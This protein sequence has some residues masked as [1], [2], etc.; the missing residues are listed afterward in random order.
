MSASRSACLKAFRIYPPWLFDATFPCPSRRNMRA[1]GILPGAPPT[2][3]AA[4]T[5]RKTKNG[6][7]VW[8]SSLKFS[9]QSKYN[10][11]KTA[12]S[13]SFCCPFHRR[14]AKREPVM[15]CSV[16]KSTPGRRQRIHG[17]AGCGR[18]HGKAA[19]MPTSGKWCS[20]RS[21][22]GKVPPFQDREE[23]RSPCAERPERA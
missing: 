4:E 3:G 19:G 12:A 17:K 14:E 21:P 13:T 6:R 16:L 2:G 11:Q 5:R 20:A 9:F 8:R 7:P 22:C 23:A 18:R 15:F 1:S 10:P